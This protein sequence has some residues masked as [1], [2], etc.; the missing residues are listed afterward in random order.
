MENKTKELTILLIRLNK[1]LNKE[2]TNIY[3]IL[4][5]FLQEESHSFGFKPFADLSDKIICGIDEI[6]NNLN[7]EYLSYECYDK[8]I[9]KK[10]KNILNEI[11]NKNIDNTEELLS[12]IFNLL[13][14]LIFLDTKIGKTFSLFLTENLD[15]SEKTLFS[16]SYIDKVI[17]YIITYLDRNIYYKLNFIDK[18]YDDVDGLFYWFI[19]ENK[20]G[21]KELKVTTANKELE[22]YPIKNYNDFFKFINFCKI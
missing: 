19:I 7:Y 8:D 11:Y 6:N 3:N 9:Y 20:L 17:F 12:L 16:F 1:L 14:E 10:E 5:T 15:C 21:K 4:S 2:S 22:N 13:E 18:N